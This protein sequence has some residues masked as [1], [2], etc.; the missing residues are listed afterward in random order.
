MKPKSL[1]WT[2]RARTASDSGLDLCRDCFDLDFLGQGVNILQQNENKRI[3]YFFFLFIFQ[4]IID[5]CLGLQWHVTRD[6]GQ[7][8]VSSSVSEKTPALQSAIHSPGA[9]DHWSPC[10]SMSWFKINCAWI[11]MLYWHLAVNGGLNDCFLSTTDEGWTNDWKSQP[12][13]TTP[14]VL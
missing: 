12:S 4:S 9:C 1:N 11:Q 10:P 7:W 13:S 8:H 6:T 3:F 2:P 14:D 5:P